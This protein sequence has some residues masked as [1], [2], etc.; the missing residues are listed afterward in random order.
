MP[1]RCK[2][3]GYVAQAAT[4]FGR[5]YPR[6]A[7]AKRNHGDVHQNGVT[8]AE[9]KPYVEIVRAR[10]TKN[11]GKPAWLSMEARWI[12]LVGIADGIIAEARK[13]KP[14]KR[15]KRLAAY[16]LRRLGD[17][18]GPEKVIETVL[19]LYLMQDRDPQRFRS[20]TAFWTQLVRRVRGL[21]K[22]NAGVWPD[23]E[24]GKSKIAYS[25]LD[26]GT[27]GTLAAWIV[28]ALGVAG[29]WLVKLERHEREREEQ[30]RLS[31]YEELKELV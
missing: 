17:H 30:E 12:A 31:F 2:A 16:E 25:V 15:Y 11:P 22:V 23:S 24:T 21:T 1:D 10:K 8:K 13:G 20:D 28:E 27:T 5:Y 6:H 14:M 26:P 9:L 4:E 3:N 7:T 19:A 29:V 18:V